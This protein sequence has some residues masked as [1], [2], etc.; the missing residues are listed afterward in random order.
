MEN[1]SA[2]YEAIRN[3]NGS[4]VNGSAITVEEAKNKKRQSATTTK[5]FVGNIAENVKAADIRALFSKYGSV[6]ECDLVRNYG[7][8]VS[9]VHIV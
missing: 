5:L 2:G 3:L 7:F 9:K 1:S 4:V 6:A 8:V